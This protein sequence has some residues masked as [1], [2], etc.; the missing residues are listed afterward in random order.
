VVIAVNQE[1]LDYYRDRWRAEMQ[2]RFG[3]SAIV[4]GGA[5]RQASVLAAI[6]ATDP[7]AEIVL[8]H[9]AV[10]PLVQVELVEKVAARAAECGAAIAAVPAVATVKE[11][12]A[13]GIIKNTP[14]R[15]RLWIA[16][17][18]QG[19]RRELALQAHR[20]AQEDGFVGTDDAL[21]VERM[22]LPVAVVEDRPDNIKITTAQDL[23]VAEAILRQQ[24]KDG[25]RG[26]DLSGSE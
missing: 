1:D 3:V 23:A 6:E 5:V 22:G 12:D 16:Q 24:R 8:I 17:T 9:D 26:A 15:D 2:A 14:P 20:K 21:L 4:P 11:V 18:P 19:F 10:R 7:S 13:Q 25:L